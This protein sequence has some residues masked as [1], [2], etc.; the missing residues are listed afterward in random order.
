[1][2]AFCKNFHNEYFALNNTYKISYK[3]YGIWFSFSFIIYD[4]WNFYEK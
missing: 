2:Y 3:S 1:M 4:S